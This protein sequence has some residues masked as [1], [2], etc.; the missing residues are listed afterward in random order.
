MLDLLHLSLVLLLTYIGLLANLLHISV[1][2]C[3]Q[4][5]SSFFIVEFRILNL[6]YHR[7]ASFLVVSA[8]FGV[9]ASYMAVIQF[10]IHTDTVPILNSCTR[11][12]GHVLGKTTH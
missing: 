6:I 10:P 4:Q 5:Y 9:Y 8:F 11:C 12:A 3:F 1:Y 2:I 7:D